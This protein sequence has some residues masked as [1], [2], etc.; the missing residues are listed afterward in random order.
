MV[1]RK[2]FVG[3]GRIQKRGSKGIRRILIKRRLNNEEK[4]GLRRTFREE[5]GRGNKKEEDRVRSWSSVGENILPFYLMRTQV[6][7]KN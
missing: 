2:G 4:E 6:F 7:R 3:E 1:R 5:R